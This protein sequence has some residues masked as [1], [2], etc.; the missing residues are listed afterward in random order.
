VSDRYVWLEL[1]PPCSGAIRKLPP[2]R[3]RIAAKTL[4]ESNLGRQHQSMEPSIPTRAAEDI[5]PIKPYR[6]ICEYAWR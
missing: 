6:S 1:A 5:S 2:S 3:P 4:A